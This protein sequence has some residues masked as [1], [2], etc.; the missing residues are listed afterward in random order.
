[1]PHPSLPS[2][3]FSSFPPNHLYPDA[4]PISPLHPPRCLI[5]M[6]AALDTIRL[7]SAPAVTDMI[8]QYNLF[9][10]IVESG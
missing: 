4:P 10:T 3:V 9:P 8:L 2:A 6:R 5:K 7:S 1:M